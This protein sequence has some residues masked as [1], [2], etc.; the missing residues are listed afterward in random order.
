MKDTLQV[1]DP[2]ADVNRVDV[3]THQ[4]RITILRSWNLRPTA[5]LRMVMEGGQ[6]LTYRKV[7]DG[8]RRNS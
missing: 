8:D 1:G 2:D 5:T 6:N 7:V 4:D 3:A